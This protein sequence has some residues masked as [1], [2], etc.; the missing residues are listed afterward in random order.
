MRHV[1]KTALMPYS[2]EQIYLI[3]AD[4][5]QYR[6]F[7]PW[8]SGSRVLV[9]NEVDMIGELELSAPGVKQTFRT[10]NLFS[11][12]TSITMSLIEGPFSHLQ[13]EWNFKQLGSDGCR[14][15]MSLQFAFNH[16][17]VERT[18]GSVFSVAAE[19]LVTAFSERADEIYGR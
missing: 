16:R 11:P 4:V 6:E 12:Y 19:K 17:L 3:V 2:A 1:E 5:A 18:F 9:Q 13:G 7:L 15:S 14:V 8:C 10:K